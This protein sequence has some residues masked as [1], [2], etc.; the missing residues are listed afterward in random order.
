MLWTNEKESILEFQGKHRFLSNFSLYTVTI[1]VGN[2]FIKFKT[3]E[4]AYQAF[5]TSDPVE[6]ET[7][8]NASHPAEAKKLGGKFL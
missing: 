8:I 6:F 3:S 7:I 5:K 4:H 1:P 2:T